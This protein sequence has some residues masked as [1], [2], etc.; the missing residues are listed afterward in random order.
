MSSESSPDSPRGKNPMDRPYSDG[1]FELHPSLD[2]LPILM[3]VKDRDLNV[4]SAN[5]A[6]CA[7]LGVSREDLLGQPTRP[8]LG[9]AGEK[10]DQVDQE[11]ISTGQPRLGIVETYASARGPRSV[12]TDKMPVVDGDGV[13][14]GL[15]GTST[16]ITEQILLQE[17]LRKSK[18]ESRLIV[19]SISEHVILQDTAHHILWANPAAAQSVG[20]TVEELEGQRCY[21]VWAEREEPCPDCPVQAAIE[22][23]SSKR[24]EQQTLDGRHWIVVGSPVLDENGEVSGAVEV[25]LETTTWKKAEDELRKSEEALRMLT[26]N[27]ADVV[28]TMDLGF[29]TTYVSPSVERMLGFTQEERKQQVLHQ[30]VT[31]ESANAILRALEQEL[32]REQEGSHDPTRAVTVEAE[33]YHKDGSTLWTENVV[34]GLRDENGKLVG[35]LGVA[36]DISDRKRAEQL[37]RESERKHRALITSINDVVCSLDAEG[38]VTYISPQI[39]TLGGIRPHE[40]VGRPLSDFVLQED[41]PRIAQSWERLRRGIMEPAVFRIRDASGRVRHVRTSCRPHFEEG[42]FDGATC[43]MADI[44]WLVEVEAALRESEEKYRML[45]EQSVDAISLTAPDGRILDANQAWF[46]FFGYKPADL[47]KLNARDSYA[48]PS[49]R[50][51]FLKLIATSDLVT[52]EV[53]VRRKDGALIDVARSVKVR[54]GQDGEVVGYQSVFHDI[55]QQKQAVVALRESEHRMRELAGHLE[56]AREKERTAL[57]RDLH[58]Q[59]GQGLTALR[60]DLETTMQRLRTT[61][62]QSAAYL[63]DSVRLVDK[64]AEEV[65][66]L[67]AELRP[68]MLDDLGLCAAIE[69]HVGQFSERTAIPCELSLPEDDADMSASEATAIYRILQELLTNIARHSQATRAKV[70]L[71]RNGTHLVL[72][73]EDNGKG[74]DKRHINS[75]DS[76]GLLGIRERV[77]PLGGG[78]VIEGKRGK[79]TAV[80]VQ[81]PIEQSDSSHAKDTQH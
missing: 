78:M 7:A 13:V 59:C 32:R 77:R 51:D 25:R 35:I 45:F 47:T 10:S 64:L 12:L 53:T 49:E 40:V 68:G 72:T 29:H 69:W 17:H 19:E 65:R 9:K 1:L 38:I 18:A 43:S 14:V 20:A 50:D 71:G 81:L 79:G 61:D 60:F 28:Y 67:S 66:S 48:R 36:R 80:V 41:L 62:S 8:L 57:A 74:I 21:E 73:V 15:V 33:Y 22:S 34:K 26:D 24:G 16:D 76:L 3:C 11:V 58:D 6:F 44:S 31:P 63:A 23:R 5:S 42:I 39:E 27:V 56:N 55:T 37:L 46:R 52:D 4:V 54:R 75:N 30:M 2:G 70:R